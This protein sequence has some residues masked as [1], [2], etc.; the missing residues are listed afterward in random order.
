MGPLITLRVEA[1]LN[2][3]LLPPLQVKVPATSPN[4]WAS[5]KRD[6]SRWSKQ[7]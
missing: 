1:Q 5:N 4:I 2:Q 7:L 6:D 3:P